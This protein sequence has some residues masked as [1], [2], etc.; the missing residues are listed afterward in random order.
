MTRCARRGFGSTPAS[1]CRRRSRSRRPARRTAP[2]IRTSAPSSRSSRVPTPTSRAG[3]LL[4]Q[5]HAMRNRYEQAE[6]A[7]AAVEPLAPGDPNA[8]EY[9]RQ[10]LWLYHWGLRRADD[11]DALLDRARDVVRRTPT[12]GGSSHGSAAPTPH[13]ATGI[14]AP[15]EPGREHDD[16]GAS[17]E[18]RRWTRDDADDVGIPRRSGAT[19]QRRMRSR[20][21]RRCRSAT[22]PMRPRSAR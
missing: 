22:L 2:A 14:A 12:G 15:P 18:A 17:D 16:P 1:R 11:S 19:P 3:M 13:W 4:A 7:L 5:S 6:A 10:R 20:P 21:G 9:L 8:R